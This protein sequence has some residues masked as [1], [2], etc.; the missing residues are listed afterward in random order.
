ML[1]EQTRV[2][3]ADLREFGSRSNRASDFVVLLHPCPVVHNR[4]EAGLPRTP[5]PPPKV[6]QEGLWVVCAGWGQGVHFHSRG[7]PRRGGGSQEA[8]HV[9]LRTSREMRVI[10]TLFIDSGFWLRVVSVQTGRCSRCSEFDG[11]WAIE[12]AKRNVEKHYAV[13]GVLEEFELTLKV[14]EAYVPRFFQ[15]AEAIY[16]G[17]FISYLFL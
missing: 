14:L 10:W 4:E 16:K 15:G 7:V 12:E 6:A 17:G 3:D 5:P 8:G 1:F 13:V 2:R 11:R 9:L